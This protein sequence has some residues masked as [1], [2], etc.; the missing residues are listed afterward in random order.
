MEE[1]EGMIWDWIMMLPED[2]Q[3]LITNPADVIEC[4]NE[5]A[6]EEIKT[7]M[8]EIMKSRINYNS[9]LNNLRLHLHNIIETDYSSDEEEEEQIVYSD[10]ES[11]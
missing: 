8:W 11:E 6:V 9:I 10:S 2:D 4:I 1:V 5:E 3:K 7:E